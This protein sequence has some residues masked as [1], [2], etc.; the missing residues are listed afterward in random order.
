MSQLSDCKYILFSH[1]YSGCFDEILV[2]HLISV[3]GVC[4][5]ESESSY[6]TDIV[7]P[8]NV[9]GSRDW[10]LFQINDRYWCQGQYAGSKNMCGKNCEGTS[11]R[12]CR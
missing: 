5:V 10:G 11:G 8:P 7:G 9:D 3:A 6:R 2:L 4:L 12:V 1:I